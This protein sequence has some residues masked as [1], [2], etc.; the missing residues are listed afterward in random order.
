MNALYLLLV[1]KLPERITDG[2]DDD[3]VTYNIDLNDEKISTAASKFLFDVFNSVETGETPW[4]VII[5]TSISSLSTISENH[6]YSKRSCP[7]FFKT[8]KVNG[9]FNQFIADFKNPEVPMVCEITRKNEVC[10]DL[11][12]AFAYEMSSGRVSESRDDGFYS[13][14]PTQVGLQMTINEASNEETSW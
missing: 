2:E 13:R 8:E 1:G 4:D 14:T 10:N 7:D 9:Y 6:S 11:R 5:D 3:L 12:R